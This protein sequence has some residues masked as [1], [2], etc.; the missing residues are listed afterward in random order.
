MS[1]WDDVGDKLKTTGSGLVDTVSGG[2]L[3]FANFKIQEEIRGGNYV[4]GRSETVISEP[5]PLPY[6]GP[7]KEAQAAAAAMSEKMDKFVVW[8]GVALGAVALFAIVRAR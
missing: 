6:D 1:F 3:D 5:S 4:P 7:Q 2:F 8:G